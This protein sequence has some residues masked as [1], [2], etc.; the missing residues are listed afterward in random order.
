MRSIRRQ[1]TVSLLLGF[2]L[3]LGGGGALIYFLSRS[4]LYSQFDARL[5]SEA[6]T[7]VTFTRQE[8]DKGVDVDFSDRYLREF[9]DEVGTRFFQLARLDGKIV[10]VSDSL[11]DTRLP[12]TAGTLEQPAYWNLGLP[13]GRPGRAVSFVFVPRS[14]GEDRRYHDP[15][16]KLSLVVAGDRREL[17]RTLASLRMTLLVGGAV[18]LLGTLGLVRWT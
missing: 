18:S 12:H 3:L 13:N 2:A 9:D 8:P 14:K 4:A 10:E 11:G 7:I 5:R 15:N 6:L 1:L 16:F 17:A